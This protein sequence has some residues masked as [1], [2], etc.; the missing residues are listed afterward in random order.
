MCFFLYLMT[1]WESFS[2]YYASLS[3]NHVV[4]HKEFLK[5]YFFL[6][7]LDLSAFCVR[8]R[9]Y[10]EQEQNVLENDVK[11]TRNELTS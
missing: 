6:V 5:V 9:I 7:M 2:Q 4:S 11:H 10:Q 8:N 1:L 3:T